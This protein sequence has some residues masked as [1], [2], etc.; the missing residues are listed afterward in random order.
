M[1]SIAGCSGEEPSASGQEPSA[2]VQESASPTQV[3]SAEAPEVAAVADGEKTYQTFCF[4]CH[5][6]GLSGAPKLGDVEAWAPRIAQGPDV[7]LKR[8][9]EGIPPAMPPRGLCMGCSDADL[10]AV[11]E[12]MVNASQ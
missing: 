6:A 7:L 1:I 9:I 3:A 11:V 8:T 4:S 2:S 10:A 12:Y 5:A